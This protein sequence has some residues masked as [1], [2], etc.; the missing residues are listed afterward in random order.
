MTSKMAT[1]TQ[2]LKITFSCPDKITESVS[3]LVGVLS[4]VGV[5]IR[6]V[7]PSEHNE[8]S[9]YFELTPGTGKNRKEESSAIFKKVAEELA[10]LFEIYDLIL[11]E[12]KTEILDDQD[13]ATCWQ[14]YFVPFEIIPGLVIKPTW[15]KYTPNKKQHVLEMD[16]GMAFGTGQ[17]ESTRLALL[18][19]GSCFKKKSELPETVLDV[20][21]G[22]GILAMAT[23]TFG[24]NN[25][26]AIDND[27]QAVSVA[28]EN[29]HHN[30]L[31]RIVQVSDSAL[32]DIQPSFDLICA[33][34]VHDV[35]VAM[36]QDFKRLLAP[37]GYIVLAGIL[38][39]EQEKNCI[40]V[41]K[42]LGLQPAQIEY[43]GEWA[44]ILFKPS[45]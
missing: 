32:A 42:K 27:P 20:G 5:N 43:D 7:R 34:I 41:Y 22:T 16:P 12:L 17:H 1:A 30:N 14:K 8:I 40:Q 21:T 4:G 15:E 9:G 28:A 18:L 24:A 2:W 44:G 23:A 35:L 26:T 10:Q 39:G 31:N 25:V 45:G 6:P 33:N 13:W 19:I 36:A 3:D 11:P 29:I 38:Q 37:D